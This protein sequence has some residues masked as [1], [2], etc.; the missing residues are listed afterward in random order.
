MTLAHR[1]ELSRRSF[2]KTM[3]V[4]GVSMA[5][6]GI[7]GCSPSN[8]SGAGSFKPGTY[9]ASSQGKFGPVHVE[10]TFSEDALV[11]LS[12]TDHEET[13]FISDA[14][15]ERVPA[16][17]VEHQALDVDAVTGAT[18]TSM[19]I[20]AAATDCVKQAGGKKL[21]GSYE[22]PAP[23]TAVEDIEADVVIVGAGGSGT[24]AAL[25]AA[26]LG[27]KKVVVLEKSCTIG[28]NAL[29]SGGYLE[30]VNAPDELREEM[31]D[32]YAAELAGELE[33]AA[34]VMPAEDL[35]KLQSDYDAWKASGSTKVFDSIYLHALQ[36]KLQGEGEYAEMLKTAENIAD[37]D[38]WLVSEG[39]QFKELCGIVGYSW[40]RWTSPVEG[41][42]GQ[43]YFMFYQD[44]IEKNDYPVEIYLNT[45]ANE[46]I[47]E[48]STVVGA[49]ATGPDG[50][51]YRVRGEK[52]V[53]LATGGFSGNPDML[54][55]Y[56]TMW[57]FKEGV[58]IP[59][60]NAYG[61]TGDGITMGLAAGGTVALMD[62]Q[63]PFPFADCKNST[64]ETTV[65]DDVDCVIVN[66]EGKRFMDEVKDRYT[67]TQHIME[68]TDQQM[69]MISDADTC[70]VN[71]DV[72]RYGHSLQSLIDQGQLYRADTIEEL[73]EQIGCG[74][75]AL[76]ET[77]ERYNEIARAGEDP[78]FGR[79]TFSEESPIENP[80]F[81]AS[82]RTWAMHITVG[83]LNVD[84]HDGYRVLD[85]S[86]APIPGLRAIGETIVGSCGIGVQGEG[87]AVAKS[88]FGGEGA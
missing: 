41:V 8:N 56:N 85:E 17:I 10:A 52:G 82:P 48:D 13:K 9:T 69:F 40:P 49:Q 58:D 55:E 36:Y 34:S 51:T 30:Y 26:R 37:L 75:A 54:R 73:G 14:A 68:Q 47:I 72:N 21:G 24:V 12:V 83:G 7:T 46:L 57:P 80:P 78:D 63:M 88:L 87:F 38:E 29:V 45:P 64:D 35:A 74:G 23:S 3:T 18:L 20:M 4:A 62:T 70:R 50:T 66:K 42:C 1:P 28:G 44:A 19:A 43:G 60:T 71:G 76:K 84:I 86:G 77:V 79:T 39:F 5:V 32:S 31:T 53:I 16:S 2:V 6:F 65:G 61:H 33:Q 81:Y 25:T 11:S 59:T 27:A 15:I 67:M 22:K